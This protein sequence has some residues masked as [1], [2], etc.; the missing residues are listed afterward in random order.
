MR[1]IQFDRRWF[2]ALSGAVAVTSLQGCMSVLDVGESG[3]E[4]LAGE[5]Q[6]RSIRTSNGLSPLVADRRLERAALEQ[7]GYM[8]QSGRMVHSTGWRRDFATRMKRN[9][10]NGTAAENLAHGR[11]GVERMFEMW[12]ASPGH[13]RNMLNPDFGR[14]GLAYTR[15]AGGERRYWALV[16]A[17]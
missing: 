12:M 1:L 6:L 8:A 9:D 3:T 5:A 15:E 2:L 14:F 4:A 16:L 17:R 10:I 11:F 13:R 7:S